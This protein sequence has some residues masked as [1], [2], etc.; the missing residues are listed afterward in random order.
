MATDRLLTTVLRAYQGPPN[1]AVTDKILG[2][3][4]T[5][6]TH[7]NNPLNLSLLT[8]HFL[9]ARAIWQSPD[10]L[11]T[12]LRIISIYNTAAIHVRRNELENASL[13]TGQPPVGSG[14]S[15]EDWARAIAKG[16]DDRSSRWKHLLVLTGILMGMESEERRSLSWS[17]RSTLEQAV[18]KAASLALEDPIGTGRL[19][20]DATVLALTYALPLLSESNKQMLHCNVLLPAILE[21]MLGDEGFQ[22]GD[23]I[24]SITGDVPFEQNPSWRINSPSIARL[25]RLESRPLAQNM[26]PL[27]RLAAYA[28]QYATDSSI[29]LHT[30]DELLGFTAGLLEQWSNCSLSHIDLSVEAVTLSPDIL[31]GPWPMLWGLFKKIMYAVVVILQ[32]IVGRS[33]LDPHIRNDI[34]APVVAAKTLHTLHNISFISTRQGASSFQV[35]TFTYLASLDTLTRYPNACVSYLQETQPAPQ[36]G[37]VPSPVTQALLLFYLNTAEHLPLSLPTPA[38]ES[39][40]IAPA[41]AHLSPTSWLTSPSNDPP[42]ALTLELFESAHSAVLSALSCP[43]HSILTAS[44]IPFYIDT[45]L[46]AF[47]SRISPRQFRLA[48]RT[49]MQ[50]TSPP[51][52]IS[53]THPSLSETLLETVRFRAVD[54]GA[55]THPLMPSSSPSPLPHPSSSTS[56][57]DPPL[58]EQ[59]AL[60]LALIDALPYAPLPAMDEWLARAAEAANA[61]AG[62]DHSRMRD[63]ARR[64]FCDVLAGPE[65]DVERAARGVAWW[66]SRGGRELL[67][68]GRYPPDDGF[69]MSGAL[70]SE[71]ESDGG[72][73][74]R[75]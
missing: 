40:I 8:S 74:S 53:T 43:Q 5:L 7:L 64:R 69:L 51:Y 44:L 10:G 22:H 19:G 39:L 6:L 62:A 3:T 31:Q 29:V 36:T 28:V 14:V 9:T 13:A 17:L 34:V 63:V 12:C 25:Q 15:A 26:G 18:I 52:P 35:Y 71:Q 58:S 66:G 46:A 11:R 49:V 23:F 70:V 32:P 45:L 4:N 47:P 24:S 20:R 50:I 56:S 21:A 27:S 61:I 37:D 42:S 57:T 59:A 38:C 54:G 30:Q 33:L 60:V 55:S 2:T 1:P 65:M 72:S 48:F 16:A 73:R 67:L 75:L 68:F 41:T